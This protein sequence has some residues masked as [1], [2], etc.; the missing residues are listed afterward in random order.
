[1]TVPLTHRRLLVHRAA[2][3]LF[4]IGCVVAYAQTSSTKWRSTAL[5]EIQQRQCVGGSGGKFCETPMLCTT[6]QTFCSSKKC[7]PNNQ[8]S[9]GSWHCKDVN[10]NFLD[11][12]EG[13]S[14][15]RCSAAAGTTQCTPAQAGGSVCVKCLVFSACSCTQV[16]TDFLCQGGGFDHNTC[17]WYNQGNCTAG[18]LCPNTDPNYCAGNPP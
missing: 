13:K 6:T 1:M 14:P 5:T 12:V 18:E 15:L 9:D 11:K 8:G 17:K 2:A 16:G 4:G 3:L 7:D 10:N